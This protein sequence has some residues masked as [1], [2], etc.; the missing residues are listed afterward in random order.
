MSASG[1]ALGYYWRVECALRNHLVGACQE[2]VSLSY[3]VL[4]AV[5]SNSGHLSNVAQWQSL[6]TL[7]N[8]TQFI[9]GHRIR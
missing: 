9:I 5:A 2:T 7:P 3:E 4:G 1:T 8:E 6:S